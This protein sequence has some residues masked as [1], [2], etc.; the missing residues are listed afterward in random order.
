MDPYVIVGT[1]VAGFSAAQT[2]RQR[3]PQAEIVLIGDEPEGYYSR[4]GLA[5]YLTRE[6]P[7]KSLYPMDKRVMEPLGLR[8]IHGRV[9][10]VHAGERLV[11]LADG[12]NLRYRRLLIATGASAARLPLP[13][14]DLK[15]VVKLDTLADARKIAKLARRRRGA[16]VIGGGITAL[17]IVEGLLA[18]GMK[19]HYFLRGERYWANVLDEQES[20]VVE[21]RLREEGVRVHYRTEASQ[22]EGKRGRVD[23]V[24]TKTGER[25]P[26]RVVGVA[27]GIRPRLRLALDLGLRVDRGILVDE[28]MQTSIAGIYAAGDVAQVYDPATGHYNLDSLWNPARNQGIVAG[29]NMA[30]VP[31]EYRKS[32]PF[33]VTR[34][35]GLTT[36]IIGTVGSGMDEDLLGIARGDSETWRQLPDAIVAQRGF[37][38]NR[39]RV[40][41]GKKHILG[42]VVMGD[43]TLSQPLQRLIAARADI[44]PI[45]RDLLRPDAPLAEILLD[46]Y[47]RW[48]NAHVQTQS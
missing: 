39:L 6:L 26:C 25:I 10:R 23:A 43:Q 13:G 4:P 11:E 35:A 7:E 44:T 5:Y 40:L 21:N 3:D 2:I 45:H 14:S 20:R 37:D 17:E 19:V 18:R 16:V 30:G 9:E 31:T 48:R 8:F 27:V 46:F 38:V 36:T 47:V 22:I 28:Y 34:L 1:G 29:L 15:G 32:T 33:N 42:A 24:I 12:R 41:L